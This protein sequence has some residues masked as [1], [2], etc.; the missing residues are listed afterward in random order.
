MAEALGDDA[1]TVE[2]RLVEIERTCI[3]PIRAYAAVEIEVAG[4]AFV[5]QGLTVIEARGER[6][7]ELPNYLRDGRRFPTFCLPD[8]LIEPVGRLVL[9]AYH[10]ATA[11]GDIRSEIGNFQLA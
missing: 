9:D 8:E 2:L 7:V 5:I 6:R 3:G 11:N 1:Q 4:V 10:D